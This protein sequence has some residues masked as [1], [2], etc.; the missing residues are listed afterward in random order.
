MHR[1]QDLL[2]ASDVESKTVV[3]ETPP[4]PTR[5][6]ATLSLVTEAAQGQNV[7]SKRLGLE[8]NVCTEAQI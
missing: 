4:H 5:Q 2:L 3:S 7:F 1:S 8:N 6:L